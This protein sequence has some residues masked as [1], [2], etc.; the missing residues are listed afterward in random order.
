MHR[1]ISILY[2]PTVMA[3]MGGQKLWLPVAQAACCTTPPIPSLF[4]KRKK[5]KRHHK[6]KCRIIPRLLVPENDFILKFSAF[7]TAHHKKGKWSL[8]LAQNSVD[9]FSF[10]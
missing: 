1:A 9:F 6:Q 4:E 8:L 3:A 2:P 5:T 7:R 10:V